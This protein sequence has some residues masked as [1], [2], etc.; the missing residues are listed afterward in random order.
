MKEDKESIEKI[1]KYILCAVI[2]HNFL[3]AENDEGNV[4]FEED[5]DCVSG[6]DTDNKL[7]CPVNDATDEQERRN[8][9]TEYFCEKYMQCVIN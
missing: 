1:I 7:N 3:I 6:I 9:L 5:D 8:Q 2:L 4:F